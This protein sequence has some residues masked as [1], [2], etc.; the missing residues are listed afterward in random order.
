MQASQLKKQLEDAIEDRPSSKLLELK[1][2]ILSPFLTEEL[3]AN[4]LGT[5]SLILA[6][7]SIEEQLDSVLIKGTSPVLGLDEASIEVKLSFKKRVK[8]AV[9]TVNLPASQ[10]NALPGLDW[11]NWKSLHLSLEVGQK[12]KTRTGKIIGVL[13]NLPG[14]RLTGGLAVDTGEDGKIS[15]RTWRLSIDREPPAPGSSPGASAPPPGTVYAFDVIKEIIPAFLNHGIKSVGLEMTPD[16]SDGWLSALSLETDFSWDMLPTAALKRLGL[17]F[18][19]LGTMSMKYYKAELTAAVELK[20]CNKTLGF[21]GGFSKTGEGLNYDFSLQ[22]S[23]GG[24]ITLEDLIEAFVPGLKESINPPE[25]VAEKLRDNGF[26][27][28]RVTLS[29]SAPAFSFFG[30]G[31]LFGLDGEAGFSLRQM[32]GRPSISFNVRSDAEPMSIPAVLKDILGIPVS[33]E[34]ADKLPGV[35]VALRRLAFDQDDGTFRLE[36][37]F[38][39]GRKNAYRLN[40]GLTLDW[41]DGLKLGFLLDAGESPVKLADLEK[42]LPFSLKG[43]KRVVPRPVITKIG[44]SEFH[45]FAVNLDT[46]GGD[47][48]IEGT[49]NLFGKILVSASL[50]VSRENRKRYLTLHSSVYA[51]PLPIRKLPELIGIDKICGTDVIR[52]LPK[53]RLGL[54]QILLDQRQKRFSISGMVGIGGGRADTTFGIQ[55]HPG[56][57]GVIIDIGFEGD[58]ENPPSLIEFLGGVIPGVDASDIH[59]PGNLDITLQTLNLH[60]DSA[61]K[62]LGGKAAGA[63]MVAG[64]SVYLSVESKGVEVKRDPGKKR[65]KLTGTLDGHLSIGNVALAAELNL[66]DPKLTLKQ[67]AGSKLNFK[68]VAE[69]FLGKTLFHT[70]PK[71]LANTLAGVEINRF[72]SYIDFENKGIFLDISTGLKNIK[73]GGDDL[74]VKEVDIALKLDVSDN[75]KYCRIDIGGSGSI[76]SAIIFKKCTFT[77]EYETKDGKQDRSLGGRFDAQ[78]FGH[79]MMVEAG[80]KDIDNVKTMVLH[81][82]DPFPA[83]EFPGVASFELDDFMLKVEKKEEEKTSWGL[84]ATFQFK[85]DA[86]IFD[87]RNGTVA[88]INEPGKTGLML[89]ADGI[90]MKIPGSPHLPWFTMDKPLLELLSLKRKTGRVWSVHGKTGF[91]VHNIPDILSKIFLIENVVAECTINDK[92]AEFS[93][94]LEDGLIKL[95]AP[96]GIGDFGNAY[97]GINEMKVNLMDGGSLTAKIKFGLPKGLNDI[98]STGTDETGTGEKGKLEIFRVYD[99]DG[100]KELIGLNMIISAKRGLICELDQSPFTFFEITE[101]AAGKK[102]LDIDMKKF[103]RVTIDMP[104]LSLTPEGSISASGG[105]DI[106]EDLRIPLTPLKYLLDQAGLSDISKN[107]NDGIPLKGIDFY[108]QRKGETRKHFHTDAFFELFTSEPGRVPIPEWLKQGFNIVDDILDRLPDNFLEYGN[109]EIPKHLHFN[110]DFTPDGSLTFQV[111]VKDPES[112][113]ENEDEVVPI[114]MLLPTF[115]NFMGIELYSLAFGELFGGALLRLDVDMKIDAFN[116]PSMLAALLFPYDSMPKEI[117]SKLPDPKQFHNSCRIKNLLIIIIYQAAGV[118]IPIPLFFDE[119]SISYIGP[120]GVESKS[121]FG[122][123]KPKLDLADIGTLITEFIGFFKDG[124]DIDREKVEKISLG[125]FIIGPNYMRLP[126]YISTEEDNPEVGTLLGTEEGFTIKPVF[127]FCALLNAV[128]N[129]SINELIQVVEVSRRVGEFDMKLF[130]LL[131]VHLEYALTTPYEFIDY[132]YKEL[133]SFNKDQA[134]EYLEI[135]PPRKTGIRAVEDGEDTYAPIT[136]NT[137]GLVIFMKGNLEIAHALFYD[138]GFGLV[139]SGD[140]FAVGAQFDGRL[141]NIV[142]IHLRGVIGIKKDGTFLLEGDARWGILEQDLL[143]GYFCFHNEGLSIKGKAGTGPVRMEGELAGTF[144]NDLFH[145]KGSAALVIFNLSVHGGA[146]I[147]I[148]DAKKMVCLHG[149]YSIGEFLKLRVTLESQAD[150]SRAAMNLN[151]EGRLSNLLELSLTASAYAAGRSLQAEGSASMKVLNQ[152]VISAV[153]E[154]K[155]DVIS[156]R[157]HLD[158]FPGN[159]LLEVNGDAAGMLSDEAFELS[160]DCRM[161]IVSCPF[162]EARVLVTDKKMMFTA[163]LFGVTTLL[164]VGKNDAGLMLY[165]G[166]SPIIMGKL[167]SITGSDQ[168]SG[169]GAAN[170]GGPSLLVSTRSPY[171]MLQGR[172]RIL[173]IEASTTI[174]FAS[175]GFKFNISGNIFNLIKGELTVSGDNFDESENISIEGKIEIGDIA[176]AVT[177]QITKVAGDINNQ[178]DL[179]DNKLADAEAY[180]RQRQDEVNRLDGQIRSCKNSINNLKRQID[181]KKRWYHKSPWYKKSYR[182]IELGAYVSAKGVKIA[183]LYAGIGVLEGLKLTAT[184]LLEVAKAAV[185]SGRKMIKEAIGLNNTIARWSRDVL[186]FGSGL[187]SIQRAQFSSSLDSACGGSVSINVDLTFMNKSYS[188]KNIRF[189]LLNPEVG[190]DS[191]VKALKK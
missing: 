87:L 124:K 100:A 28:L 180:L 111:S 86:D 158:L 21:Q 179:L 66:G 143:H 123:P 173:G 36:G 163:R 137:E 33:P 118:P 43:I 62:S 34:A 19:M 181:A 26:E 126:K 134:R 171:F 59:L 11:I 84:S 95:P 45:R 160:G 132:A 40:G 44:A 99:P 139:A 16:G 129:G 65:K 142:G 56:N 105:F 157:G 140:G 52:L 107:I 191:I 91:I 152:E 17:S 131:K 162:G 8:Q 182:W 119:L 96:P 23:K 165:G 57:S 189:S 30:A 58:T 39:P 61:S 35:N 24:V 164:L 138:V 114:K 1:T 153:V 144:T 188:L 6:V 167:L 5:E 108:S 168:A 64:K 155:T 47:F 82:K 186:S 18:T 128:K 20:N 102:I 103:G 75:R 48:S 106:K 49:A 53:F 141:G 125:D 70:L 90:D 187:F 77:F 51:D 183:A 15:G 10:H 146:E 50:R 178:L 122:F 150:S 76:G 112:D 104:T 136:E 177:K 127:L 46:A 32:D 166:M 101:D 116:L 29:P 120:E 135:L 68:E 4:L 9:V 25:N 38:G 54:R 41:S 185:S 89:S 170:L 109:I 12:N 169:M 174:V 98:F 151:M 69:F 147:L 55:K 74:L 145:L 149:D 72:E 79:N 133:S 93:I 60:L 22:S 83:I 130:D 80:Y 172:V 97:I 148:S 88:L 176:G 27:S 67:D 121:S 184:G 117:A 71:D 81:A 78:I 2:P 13:D 154:Y 156:F 161:K 63:L 31:R 92:K 7:D 110:L 175:N 42:D 94:G 159:T 85:T 37:E 3:G 73:L 113:P 14:Y 115:P 190:V